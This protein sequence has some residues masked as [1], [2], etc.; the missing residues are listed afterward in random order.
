MI[1]FFETVM[2][3]QFYEGTVPRLIKAIESTVKSLDQIATELKRA[4]DLAEAK[5]KSNSNSGSP[6]NSGSP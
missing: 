1:Q 2:G 4:N 5:S 3:K 6:W